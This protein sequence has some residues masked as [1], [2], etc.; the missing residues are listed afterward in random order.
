MFIKKI[1]CIGL[2]FFAANSFA[3][4]P[5]YS[6]PDNFSTTYYDYSGVQP[7]TDCLSNQVIVKI[8]PEY[9]DLCNSTT[10]DIPELIQVFNYVKATEIK[11]LYPMHKARVKE[12]DQ[13]GRKLSDLSL[14][15][16]ITYSGSLDVR[17]LI[18]ELNGLRY[19]EYAQPRM[20]VSPMWVP[21]D[22]SFSNQWYLTKIRADLAWNLDT[23]SYSTIIGIVDGGT[24][25]FHPDLMANIYYDY[26]DSVGLGDEDNDGFIDNFRG[27]DVGDGDNY[28]Q[29]IGGFNSA[30]GTAM[31]SLAAGS[32]NNYTGIAGAGYKC[33]YM[34][35]KMVHSSYGYVAGYEGLVYA[36]DHG[37][38]IINASWG[39]QTPGPY[40]QD[41]VNYVSVNQG[42]QIFAAA[43]NSNN[44]I[45]FYPASYEAVIAVGGTQQ[46]DTKSGN[47]SYYEQVDI[48]SPGQGMIEVY[49]PGPG[50]YG[51]GNGT[52]DASAL[53][54][55]TAGLVQNYYSTLQPI[56]I[57]AILRQ[58]AHRI[59]TI[60]GNAPYLNKQGS[61]RLDMY[62]ALINPFEPYLYFTSRTFTDNNDDVI[63]IGDTVEIAGNMLN[64][65]DTSTAALVAIISDNSP[66]VQWLDSSA[67]L[68]TINTMNF[69]DIS[70][71]PFK[72]LTLPGCPLNQNV[73]MKVVYYDGADTLNTQ[74]FSFIV[75]RNYYNVEVNKLQ[76]TV[77]TTGRIGFADDRT[78]KGIGYRME[79]KEN[80]LLGIYWNPMG[81]FL[82]KTSTAVSDQTLSQP[83]LGPCC[84]WP[85]DADMLAMQ[86]IIVNHSSQVADLEVISQYDD[87][88]AG[89]NAVGVNVK[90]KLYAWTD[91]INDQFLIVEYQFQNNTGS[92]LSDWYAG[93]FSDFDMPDSLLWNVWFNQAFYDTTSQTA[94]VQNPS[95]RHFVG[96]KVLSPFG[97][98]KYYA[99]NTDGSGGTQ[100]VYD[101][102]TS[103]EKHN[104]MNPSVPSNISGITDVAQYIGVKFDSLTANG[105]A[106]LH[107]ALLIGNSLADIQA[108]AITAET[109]YNTTFNIWT[110]NGGNN[111][112]HDPANWTQNSVPDFA[113]HVIVPDTSPGSGFSPLISTA[114]G[115][116][117]N[118]E[119]RCGGRLDVNPPYKLRV[120]N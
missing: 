47:S 67:N 55:G 36:A 93:L 72:F 63:M 22:T 86:N 5:D 43:G 109:K 115:L 79:G 68:G 116:V 57:G 76:T 100:N 45:P 114:D 39:G 104:M 28:P 19:V 44:T 78:L 34:P 23:G 107:F 70:S 38:K 91:S 32:T 10:I 26:T 33:S 74:Y 105:C 71:Q 97:Q 83:P 15:Y 88:G 42:C 4:N 66:F 75:N 16:N 69:N 95:P 103:T 54:S 11:K 9:R 58:S 112:W 110:G 119:I 64:L 73:L 3:Q 102:F 40:E 111:N 25:F 98:V 92:P 120:G 81:L 29:Y 80:N 31:S 106:V 56:Q 65:L 50:G 2:F 61:G 96:V 60:P 99:N 49:S 48:V 51:T 108:Q 12:F 101:G 53:T 8:K 46:N 13:F 89:A 87:N 27:W 17:K 18:T 113:D 20:I 85:N 77:T 52:S 94:I 7:G 6:F 30:H 37:A 90:Q 1:A 118:I 62:A 14:V 35:I 21:N 117:K 24:D 82:S 84:N 59:D 41:V